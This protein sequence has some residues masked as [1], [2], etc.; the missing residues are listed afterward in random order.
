[1][2]E[3]VGVQT[4]KGQQ[5]GKWAL[6]IEQ[7][8]LA[9][10]ALGSISIGLLD[11]FGILG[12]TGLA[13]KTGAL[14]LIVSGLIAG[15]LVFERNVTLD[16]LSE[17]LRELGT[18]L[19]DLS[20][21]VAPLEKMA[22]QIAIFVQGFQGDRFSELKLLYGLRSYNSNVS[23]NEIRAGQDRTFDLWAESLHDAT[24]FYAF[25]HVSPDE[26]WGTKG[27]AFNVAQSA[28]LAR[29][30]LGCSI[31]GVFVIDDANEY[32]RLKDLMTAQAIAGMEVKWALKSD[33][34]KLPLIAQYTREL[35]TWDFVV[36]DN[37][38][39]FRVLLD[40][41]RHMTSCCLTRSRGL[42]D[43]ALHLF[44]E[45][46]SAGHSFKEA[47]TTPRKDMRNGK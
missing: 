18:S 41:S 36:I 4:P 34:S 38:L 40:D 20:H 15:Y 26:V 31:K 45:A 2:N 37:D 13:S 35:G 22:S 17:S 43:K 25:N 28:Q 8:G 42:H 27:W 12:G 46:L 32:H 16:R 21:R 10:T 14:T 29:L 19:D 47:P 1:M 30:Q 39:L 7:M 23:E 33:L 5:P 11:T 3:N 6:V 9:I 44:R 24:S